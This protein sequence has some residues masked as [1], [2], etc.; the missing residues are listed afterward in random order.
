MDPA[1]HLESDEAIA[2]L[3]CAAMTTN[4][5]ACVAHALGVV[6]HAKGMTE[7]ARRTELSRELLD[8]GMS[9]L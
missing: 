6:A 9:W 1:E 7:L 2:D 4:D 3:M 5:P 8:R